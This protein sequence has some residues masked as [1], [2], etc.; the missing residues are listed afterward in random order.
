[1]SRVMNFNAGPAALPLAALERAREE[2]LDFEGSGMSVMEHSHRGKVYEKVHHEATA[3]VAKHLGTPLDTWDV[4]FVQGGA[5]QAFAQIPMNFLEAGKTADYVVNGA[6]GEKAVAEA[7]TIKAIGGGEPHVAHSTKGA[8]KSYTR[9]SKQS[10]I[11]PSKGAAFFHLT[12]NET[13]H[14]VEYA[15][16]AETPFPTTEAGVPV[17]IDMSSDILG[18]RVDASKFDLVYAG[19][20]KNIGP[21]G[22]TI[23][24]LK[25]ELTAKGRKDIP[26][27]FQY[28]TAAENQSLYNTPP[29]FGIY[30][31]R[32]TLGWLES[33]GGV[34]GVEKRNREKAKHIYDAIDGS[35]GFYRCPV[36]P[37]SRSIMNVVWRCPNE[38]LEETFVK[39]ATAAKMIGLKGHRAVGGLRASIYN[40]V[41]PAWCEAL[42]S[43]MKDFAKKHG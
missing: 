28:R 7:K 16:G 21:S 38:G 42:A 20:Q 22:V 4:L 15:L 29:T 9:V 37:A 31:V 6:W 30:L 8:D 34:E 13:I 12:S 39:E 24:A 35:G 3:L 26:T 5:S 19:A 1:M 32:N 17:V 40:A 33:L 10:E 23:V 27:I 2:L 11:Q 14:G 25:K 36:E 41:E 18:R 43:F